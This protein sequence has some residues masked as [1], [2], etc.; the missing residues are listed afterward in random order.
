MRLFPF[1]KVKIDRSFIAG[2]G[3]A[4]DCD[5]IVGA[6]IGLCTQLGMT[7]T[8]EGVETKTQLQ[9]LADLGCTEAQGFLLSRPCRME[10]LSGVC[11]I[12][13][14]DPYHVSEVATFKGIPETSGV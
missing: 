1:D 13:N 14:A 3:K 6:I 5:T 8:S 2:L 11:N 7:V 12:L 9:R 10:N 4:G